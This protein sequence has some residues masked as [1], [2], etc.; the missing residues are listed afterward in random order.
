MQYSNRKNKKFREGMSEVRKA[1]GKLKKV[2]GARVPP[3]LI[4]YVLFVFF[5]S[6]GFD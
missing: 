6:Y 4:P 5:K 1:D 3:N 2:G